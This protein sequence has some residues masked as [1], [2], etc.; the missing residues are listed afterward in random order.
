MATTRTRISRTSLRACRHI[1]ITG[2]FLQK[3]L[4]GRLDL[5]N[6]GQSIYCFPWRPCSAADNSALLAVH[7][8][9]KSPPEIEMD[10]GPSRCA[11]VPIVERMRGGLTRVESLTGGQPEWPTRKNDSS[12]ELRVFARSLFRRCRTTGGLAVAETSANGSSV[13]R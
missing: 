12:G 9:P 10:V 11:Y 3:E 1:G 2:R 5:S 6:I 4:C 7:L 8:W 13:A